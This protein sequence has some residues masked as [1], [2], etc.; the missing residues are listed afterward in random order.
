MHSRIGWINSVQTRELVWPK[1]WTMPKIGKTR[2]WPI[3]K[4]VIAVYLTISVRMQSDHLLSVGRK[5]WLF[6]TSEYSWGLKSQIREFG[7]HLFSAWLWFRF[8]GN[9]GQGL[10]AFAVR[11]SFY[12]YSCR[13]YDSTCTKGD[14]LLPDRWWISLRIIQ[15]VLRSHRQRN[16]VY[17][18]WDGKIEWF[19]YL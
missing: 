10:A 6:S 14:F 9:I 5:N 7:N 3:W 17:N 12:K 8:Y 4:A 15:P 18:G 13:N 16:C 19:E 1:R 2:W 11:S